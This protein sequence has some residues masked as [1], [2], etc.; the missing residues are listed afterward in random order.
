MDELWAVTSILYVLEVDEVDWTSL[1]SASKVVLEF[2]V[3][4]I[5]EFE[6]SEQTWKYF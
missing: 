3:I 4:L 2:I 6:E 1:N 5:V